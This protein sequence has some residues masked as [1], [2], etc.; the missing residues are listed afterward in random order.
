V[1]FILSAS[2]LLKA[3]LPDP[4]D[5]NDSGESGGPASLP[6][7]SIYAIASILAIIAGWVGYEADLK[8]LR[9]ERGFVGGLG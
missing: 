9:E 6:L 3:R 1:L 5:K 4:E 2:L 7:G 8:G